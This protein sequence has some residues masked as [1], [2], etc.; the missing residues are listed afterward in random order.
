MKDIPTKAI[1]FNMYY[2][3]QAPTEAASPEEESKMSVAVEVSDETPVFRKIYLDNIVCTGAQ[4]AVVLQGLPEMPISEIV[5]N[6]LKMTSLN[7]VSVF[8]AD[9]IK[10]K[11][12][13]IISKSEPVYKIVQSRNIL[14]DNIIFSSNEKFMRVG[15]Y[16]S[17]SIVIKNSEVD[18][19][20][21]LIEFGE[22]LDE[23]IIKIE[24]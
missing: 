13:E 10:F 15:G 23:R 5:L 24:Q 2:G 17:D 16:K 19:K 1:S 21:G 18:F 4:D 12:S 22:G 9:G 6:N 14:F 8:D 11:N 3:G 20:S 7:G